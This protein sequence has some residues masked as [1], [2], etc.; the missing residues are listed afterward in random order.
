MSSVG[1]NGCVCTANWHPSRTDYYIKYYLIWMVSVHM[2]SGCLKKLS[3]MTWQATNQHLIFMR[4][5]YSPVCQHGE[6]TA[7][8]PWWLVCVWGRERKRLLLCLN[9]GSHMSRASAQRTFPFCSVW[10]WCCRGGLW[11]TAARSGHVNP[12]LCLE[13]DQLVSSCAS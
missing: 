9:H 2:P 13:G 8:C 6:N 10:W 1:T 5:F 11:G 4:W 7:F 3:V 12:N